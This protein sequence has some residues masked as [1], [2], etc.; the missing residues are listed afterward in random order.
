MR[1][2]KP[3]ARGTVYIKQ[4]MSGI[5]YGIGVGPGDPELISLKAV[6]VLA[7]VGHVFAA[8]SPG[9]DYSLALN[10]AREHL[11]PGSAV[12][13]LPFPMTR[14]ATE[15]ES[16]W[17]CNAQRVLEVLRQG[18][19][20]AFLTLG[21]PLIYSTFGYL[22]RTVREL[23]PNAEVRAIPGITSFQA[24]AAATGQVLCESGENL[25]LMS[26]LDERAAED[27][28]LSR[29]DNIVI[30]KVYR[31]FHKLRGL[32]RERGLAGQST[33][34]SRLGLSGEIICRELDAAPAK[35]HYLSMLLINKRENGNG[36]SGE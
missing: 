12:E 32:L 17:R 8:A 16:A 21:D 24:A 10:I 1:Y 33:F 22:A 36:R 26:D 29:P 5:F 4:V 20:A 7:N 15:L 34:V 31:N 13:L 23:E 35:P 30:L 9:N 27:G 6:R 11:A 3:V 14:E 19:D 28:M 25:L 18:K 2:N